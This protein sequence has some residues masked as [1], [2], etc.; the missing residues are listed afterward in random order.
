M[1]VALH[2]QGC[3]DS[4]WRD[5]DF[6]DW[7]TRSE[8]NFKKRPRSEHATFATVALKAKKFD[9]VAKVMDKLALILAISVS[10]EIKAGVAMSADRPFS[11][12]KSMGFQAVSDD[13][14]VGKYT[15]WTFYAKYKNHYDMIMG[16]NASLPK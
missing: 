3:I 2:V 7:L 14:P 8:P 10:A 5:A 4:A 13:I 12:L 15:M 16:T 11:I 6:L 9:M 1:E